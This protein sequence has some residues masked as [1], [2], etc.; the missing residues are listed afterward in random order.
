MEEKKLFREIE[1]NMEAVI[2]RNTPL[3][4]SLWTA[5]IETH[6]A[7]CAELLS[8]IS[9]EKAKTLFMNFS[10]SFRTKVF[11]ELADAMKVIMLSAMNDAEKAEA[12]HTLPIDELTDLFDIFSDEELKDYL[13]LLNKRVRDKVLS[14]LRFEPDSAGGIMDTEALSLMTDFTVE[15]SISL[16]QRLGGKDIYQQIYVTNRAHAL[17]GHINLED[18]VLH[19]PQ[20]RIA[21]FMHKN[22]LVVRATEDQEDVAKRMV[23]YDLVTVPVVDNDNIFLGVI[24]SE[25][26]VDVIMQEASEDVQKMAAMPPMKYPYFQMSFVRLFWQRSCVLVALLVAESISGP[27]LRTYGRYL[28]PILISFIP[29]L[30][31]AGG[32]AGS[33]A[34]A[35]VIQ[36]IA[37]GEFDLANVMR[38][39]RREFLIAG[40]IAVTLGIISFLRVYFVG[41][42]VIESFAVSSAISLVIF[43]SALLGTTIP[44]ILSRFNVDPAFFAGPFLA[45]VMDILSIFIFCFLSKSLLVG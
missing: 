14:L 35:V 26:L 31:S 32:N 11:A 38:L 37:S 18:L 4:L 19:K 33:Q 1:D 28:T 15:K 22:E 44:F 23:H 2:A 39:L 13:N 29:M 45:T 21:S 16:I 24:T 9:Q 12:L 34:S 42:E 7:D 20:E 25:T 6:P 40:S 5:L 27:I 8:N 41:G 36:G 17:E 43:I 10:H 3:G 30:S